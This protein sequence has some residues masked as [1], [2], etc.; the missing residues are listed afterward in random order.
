MLAISAAMPPI[1]MSTLEDARNRPGEKKEIG[2]QYC[3]SRCRVGRAADSPPLLASPLSSPP[4]SV[5][6]EVGLKDSTC[7]S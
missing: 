7:A 5:F 3:T 2:D 1:E 4:F 6:R